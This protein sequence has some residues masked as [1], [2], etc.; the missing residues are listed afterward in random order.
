MGNLSKNILYTPIPYTKKYLLSRIKIMDI[1]DI[2]D[3]YLR[4][5]VN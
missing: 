2:I 5:G 1:L 3:I 4:N